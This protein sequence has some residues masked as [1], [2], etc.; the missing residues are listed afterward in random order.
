MESV[1][2]DKGAEVH[3]ADLLAR[4]APLM[5]KA[6]ARMALAAPALA[7]ALASIIDLAEYECYTRQKMIDGEGDREH[8]DECFR[9]C[10]AARVALKAVRL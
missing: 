7:D 4:V 10:K 5:S 2:R 1:A 6:E 3:P 8:V 9:R